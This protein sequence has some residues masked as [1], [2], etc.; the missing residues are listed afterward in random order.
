VLEEEEAE[1]EVLLGERGEEV[2][3]KEF[4][5]QKNMT[6]LCIAQKRGK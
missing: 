3:L 1:G 6:D 5:F 4:W 2:G